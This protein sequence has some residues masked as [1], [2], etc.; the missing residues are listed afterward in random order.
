V[1][2]A[3][4]EETYPILNRDSNEIVTVLIDDLTH[5]LLPVSKPISTTM[6]SDKHWKLGFLLAPRR[7]HVEK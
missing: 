6:D 1:I 3:S 2:F 7:I 4:G 5:I